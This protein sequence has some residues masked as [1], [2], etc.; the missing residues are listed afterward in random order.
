MSFL[1]ELYNYILCQ[2]HKNGVIILEMGYKE[3]EKQPRKLR[4]K[5]F[6]KKEN[7]NHMHHIERRNYGGNDIGNS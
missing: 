7:K 6:R 4:K 5:T 1:H 2:M 3:S